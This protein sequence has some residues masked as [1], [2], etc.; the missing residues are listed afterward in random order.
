IK[1]TFAY[2]GAEHKTIFCY[3]SGEELTVENIRKQKRLHPRCGSSF[4]IVM[5]FLGIVIGMLIPSMHA[6]LRT[7]IRLLILPLIV[8]IG[9]EVIM[10]AGKHDNPVMRVLTAPGIWMQLITTKEPDDKQIE[11]A[12]AAIKSALPDQFAEDEVFHGFE[13]ARPQEHTTQEEEESNQV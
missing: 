13:Y 12:I 6:I 3:E 2:H 11:V 10:F 7:G 1:R 4:M 9:Y 5:M 8:G